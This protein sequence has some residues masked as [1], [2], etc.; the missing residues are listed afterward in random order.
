MEVEHKYISTENIQSMLDEN[1]SM[2]V[3]I[4][5]L[6]NAVKHER[7]A[8]LADVQD[9]LD[10]KRKKLNRNLMTLA[11]WADE[12]TEPPVKSAPRPPPVQ[13]VPPIH[14]PQQQQ[15]QPFAAS[16]N[17]AVP[18]TIPDPIAVSPHAASPVAP[19]VV[20]TSPVNPAV[21]DEGTVD[22]PTSP[23]K[24]SALE[25][26]TADDSMGVEEAVASNEPET[27]SEFAGQQLDDSA[28][29]SEPIDECAGAVSTP[30][31]DHADAYE[32]IS[33]EQTNDQSAPEG[34]AKEGENS[35]M[36][37]EGNPV[38]APVEVATVV[39]S[40]EVEKS[41]DEPVVEDQVPIADDAMET[42][43]LPEHD[44]VPEHATEGEAVAEAANDV[45]EA[46]KDATE[47]G[48]VAKEA[49]DVEQVKKDATEGEAV[50]E[51]PDDVEEGKKDATE[52]E[53]VPEVANDVEQVKKDAT[54]GELVAGAGD[55][56]EA[57]KDA[58]EGE[59][60]AGAGDVEE[61]KKDATEGE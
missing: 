24:P 17:I 30:T 23:I 14:I 28:N 46:K 4:I 53:A 1:S 27:S 6:N 15:Q 31:P 32:S 44:E 61:A 29:Q 48:L 50:A 58:T 9:K 33:G 56:E 42:T 35:S 49:D 57:K 21:K 7:G 38:I 55:V 2:I 26:S 36:G 47:G 52:G 20:P 51:V 59:L 40:E 41:S 3:E 37:E 16:G 39:T 43:E 5:Q 18:L 60:V 13:Q 11:K 54:E 19:A 8:Q 12:S 22:V 10:K 25:E 34:D 45:E